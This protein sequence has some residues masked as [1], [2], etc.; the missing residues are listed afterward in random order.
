ME[1]P[2][3]GGG[4]VLRFRVKRSFLDEFPP[5]VVGRAYHDEHWIPAER[6]SELNDA[7]VGAIEVVPSHGDHGVRASYARVASRYADGLLDE[8]SKKPL[9]RALL[10]VFAERVRGHGLVLDLGTGPGQVARYLHDRGCWGQ[11]RRGG[12]RGS[13]P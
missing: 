10:D 12:P 7:I 11:G 6:L 9:D 3:G 4:V 5:Q 8:L 1:R 2:S 13:H